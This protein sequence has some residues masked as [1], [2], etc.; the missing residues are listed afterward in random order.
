MLKR[1]IPLSET[2]TQ[3]WVLIELPFELGELH[4]GWNEIRFAASPTSTCYWYRDY[5]RF[6]LGKIAN[7]T[8][9]I[10]R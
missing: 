6:E 9:F 1:Y 10:V 4:A 7:G 5:F 8:M 2:P 3:K